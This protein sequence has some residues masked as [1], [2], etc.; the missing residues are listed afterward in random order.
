[1]PHRPALCVTQPDRSSK[2][3]SIPIIQY[4]GYNMYGCVRDFSLEARAWW[5]LPQI[6]SSSLGNLNF[7]KLPGIP[8][9]KVPR[10]ARPLAISDPTL[11][12]PADRKTRP[13]HTK[14]AQAGAGPGKSRGK[15][16][17]E[18]REEPE[19]QEQRRRRPNLDSIKVLN[20]TLLRK[21]LSTYSKS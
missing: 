9:P 1:M 3:I 20:S 15:A 7:M 16:R 13:P 4:L 2:I 6:A 12:I 11:I 8:K 21:D 14:R 19:T 18:E 10:P 5:S 17:Q